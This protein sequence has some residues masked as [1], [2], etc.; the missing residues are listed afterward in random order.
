MNIKQSLTYLFLIANLIFLSYAGGIEEIP[1]EHMRMIDHQPYR[2]LGIGDACIDLLIPV[3][4]EFLAQVPGEKGG[5]QPI[6]IE[7]LNHILSASQTPPLIATGGS[8]ANTIKGL[9]GLQ[10]KCAF[11]SYTGYDPLGEHFSLNLKKWG[12]LGL[13]TKSQLSTSVVLCLITP[14]GQRTM[15]FYAGCSMEMSEYFLHPDYFKGIELVHLDAYTFRRG[16]LTE[17]AVALAKSS[18]AIASIDLSSF[19]VVREFKERMLTLLPEFTVVFANEKETKE[20]TGLEP[21]EGCLKLQEM[22]SIA[23]VLRG[24]KGCMVGHKGKIIHSPAFATHVVDSTGAGDLFAS[25]FL[26]GIL[27]GYSLEQCAKLGNRMGSAIVEVTG[28]ELP[29]DKWEIMQK[30]LEAEGL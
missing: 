13:F 22:C 10:E 26:Y 6:G 2:I 4:E 29:P 27:Q 23:V 20:L 30:F 11:L 25:G 16:N 1:L 7:D 14:D 24:E 19:E 8:C 15:R 21:L 18:Q 3:S 5:S 9:A 12:I 17:R 28:A